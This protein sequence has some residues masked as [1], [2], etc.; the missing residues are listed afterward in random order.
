MTR[1]WISALLALAAAA[2]HAESAPQAAQAKSKLVCFNE[3]STG[4]HIRKRTCVT[5]AEAAAR[6]K[7]DQEQMATMRQKT[8]PQAPSPG[9]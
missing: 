2:A 5:E 4:S 3:P 7:R 1:Y 6:R 8:A 9:N